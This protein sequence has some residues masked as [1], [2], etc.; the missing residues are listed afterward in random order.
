[1]RRREFITQIGGAAAVWPLAARAQQTAKEATMSVIGVLHAGSPEANVN[2]MAAFRR[3]LAE[4]GFVEGRNVAIEFRWAH[5]D[6]S[7]LPELAADL[8]RSRVAVIATP[9]GDTS[10]PPVPAVPSTTAFET[11]AVES[12]VKVPVRR[13]VPLPHGSVPFSV[14]S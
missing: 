5:N 2:V 10:Q 7:R 4:T 6:T 12:T 1:M 8:V 3:G 14:Q 13:T 9:A 11:G